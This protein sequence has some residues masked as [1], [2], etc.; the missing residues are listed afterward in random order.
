VDPIAGIGSPLGQ[1]PGFEGIDD[2]GGRARRDVKL[3]GKLR[4]AHRAVAHQ[5]AQSPHLG[6]GD[7]PG[8]QEVLGSV[9]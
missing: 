6:R 4:Q 7:V 5:H 9:A 2:L 8:S 1:A 3:A